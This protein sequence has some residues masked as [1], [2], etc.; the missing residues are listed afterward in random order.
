MALFIG[1]RGYFQ[2]P[3][4]FLID[5]ACNKDSGGSGCCSTEDRTR[6]ESEL[7][8]GVQAGLIL[9][10]LLRFPN[11][12]IA[13]QAHGAAN[14]ASNFLERW[15]KRKAEDAIATT[16]NP[17]L[18]QKAKTLLPRSSSEPTPKKCDKLLSMRNRTP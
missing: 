14:N 4:P 5:I 15:Q 10:L 9:L 17:T 13:S 6:R 1:E 12:Q 11:L 8:G 7:A 3:G 18:N 2:D 16:T